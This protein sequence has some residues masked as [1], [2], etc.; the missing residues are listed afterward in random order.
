MAFPRSLERP[1]L[2]EVKQVFRAFP[3][4]PP[5]GGPRQLG[6]PITALG[7]WP[8]LLWLLPLLGL[9]GGSLSLAQSLFTLAPQ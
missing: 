3:D 9:L 1:L 2:L 7:H 6:H 8:L 4:I 5:Q